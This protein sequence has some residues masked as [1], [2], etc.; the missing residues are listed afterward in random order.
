MRPSWTS[1]NGL[2]EL[3]QFAGGGFRCGKGTFGGEF[4]A[5]RL[6][7]SSSPQAELLHP[8]LWFLAC[9]AVRSPVI[10]PT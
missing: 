10:S 3:D 9:S 2:R 6:P 7:D 4:H 5:D 1:F 8:H